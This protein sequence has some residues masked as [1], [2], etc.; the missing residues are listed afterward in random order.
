MPGKSVVFLWC[1]N[2]NSVHIQKEKENW[3]KVPEYWRSCITFTYAVYNNKHAF[4][5]NIFKQSQ[6]AVCLSQANK[7][8][9]IYD[10]FTPGIFLKQSFQKLS[11]NGCTVFSH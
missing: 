2:R 11:W 1:Y 5:P 8:F 3:N 7:H 4:F 9:W 10:Y 6:N